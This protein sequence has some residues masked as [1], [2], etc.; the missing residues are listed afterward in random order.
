MCTAA[1]AEKPEWHAATRSQH[2]Q[3]KFHS[4]QSCMRICCCPLQSQPLYAGQPSAQPLS[5]NKRPALLQGVMACPLIL[6]AIMLNSE[7]VDESIG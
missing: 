2:S 5:H 7:S 1:G 3:P 6:P 4:T